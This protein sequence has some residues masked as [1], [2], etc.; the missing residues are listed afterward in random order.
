MSTNDAYIQ[1][2]KAKM[3][4]WDAQLDVL[5]AKAEGASA[6]VK[7]AINEQI[8][9]LESYKADAKMKFEEL[10]DAGEDAWEDLYDGVNDAWN[11]VSN[12]FT[13]AVEKFK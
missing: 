3:D 12:A 6:N 11:K 5:K 1:R 7:I 13:N 9:N 8:D 4:E 2:M 10:Q